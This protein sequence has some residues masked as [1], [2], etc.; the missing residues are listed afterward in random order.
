MRAAATALLAIFVTAQAQE[1]LIR[2]T[3]RMVEV[4]VVV[5]DKSGP[6]RGLTRDD[7][8]LFDKGKPQ[9]IAAFSSV[10]LRAHLGEAPATPPTPGIRTNRPE[11]RAPLP[12]SATVVLL[13]GINT[14]IQDQPYAKRQFLRFLK[15]VRPEDRI[16]VYA[17]G[18][19][20][21]VLHDFTGD[22]RS[23]VAAV[24][25]YTG[26]NPGLVDTSAG[27]VTDTG[28]ITLDAWLNESSGMIADRAIVDR[29]SR[30]AAA[31]EAIGN[32]IARLPGRKNLVWVSGSFP[33]AIG[34]FGSDGV[35][36]WED[37]AFDQ[38]VSGGRG[39]ANSGGGAA[40]PPRSMASISATAA[41][42]ALRS[43]STRSSAAP[44]ARSTTPISRSI[45]STRAA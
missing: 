30:T 15:Q 9:P 45:P 33:F 4:N 19:T 38:Q 44:P 36:N 40:A 16:A 22:A 42:R 35:N 5:R 20:L 31:L 10:E 32:H 13:D 2:V 8:V 26:D 25:K 43:I 24:A 29:A 21:R 18:S 34:H 23:L 37:A 6:V 14:D 17:L 12:S 27:T 7:F 39:K 11:E 41:R 28:D 1:P 3:T